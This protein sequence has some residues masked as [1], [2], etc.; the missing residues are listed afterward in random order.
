VHELLS[1]KPARTTDLGAAGNIRSSGEMGAAPL[2]M[3]A[4]DL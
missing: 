1:K 2:R 3:V 4:C